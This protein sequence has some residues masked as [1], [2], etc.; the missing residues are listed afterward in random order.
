MPGGLA[1]RQHF[2]DRQQLTNRRRGHVDRTI[3][4]SF[5]E[6]SRNPS[7]K[8]DD[9]AIVDVSQ[10]ALRIPRLDYEYVSFA[11]CTRQRT[12]SFVTSIRTTSGRVWHLAI[13]RLPRLLRA[14]PSA[15]LDVSK[16]PLGCIVPEHFP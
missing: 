2:D 8:I 11:R 13:C 16:N 9:D 4:L 3:L 7:L 12:L 6:P 14:V 10:L 5:G 15:S 1:A